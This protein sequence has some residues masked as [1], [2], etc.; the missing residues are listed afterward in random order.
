[1]N[2][3]IKEIMEER[4]TY[5]D[6]ID[7]CCDNMILNNDIIPTLASEDI[8]FELYSGTDYDEETDEYSEV[9]QY[10][11]ISGIDAERLAEYTNEIVYYNEMLDM[12]ILGVTHFGTPWNGVPAN[13]KT[14]E[15]V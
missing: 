10:Y 7:F 8:Y 5:R 13:W 3:Y 14:G 9:Y 15:E 6:M 4:A 2:N 1:M 12:Y 11:I